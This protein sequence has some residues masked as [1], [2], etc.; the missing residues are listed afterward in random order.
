MSLTD[1]TPDGRFGDFGGRFVPE[2]LIPA[3]LELEAAVD[4]PI[5]SSDFALYWRI[6]KSLGVAPNGDHG[7]LMKTLNP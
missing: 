2:T 5:I 7:R 1:P 3:V 4:K 6:F